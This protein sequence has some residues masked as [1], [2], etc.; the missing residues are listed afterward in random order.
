ML[1][2]AVEVAAMQVAALE[3]ALLVA[4]VRRVLAESASGKRCNES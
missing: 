4:V 1:A 2:V 3:V